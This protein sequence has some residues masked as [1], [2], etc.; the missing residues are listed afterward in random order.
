MLGPIE[1]GAEQGQ[2]EYIKAITASLK[3]AVTTKP[4][5]KGLPR[6]GKRKG[7]Q[8]PVF[9][10]DEAVTQ[11]EAQI[12]HDKMAK[13]WGLLEPVRPLFEPIASI[14]QPFI[15]SQ[16]VIAVLFV[17]LA[18]TWLAPAR[19]PSHGVA[20]PGYS[21]P[22]RIAAYEEIW[23]REESA[24]WDWL[25]DRTGLTD[26]VPLGAG[27][28]HRENQKVLARKL[29]EDERMSERQIDEQIRTTEEKLAGLKEAVERRR[30]KK[31]K[32][33]TA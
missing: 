31:A 18:Y 29:D 10:A 14:L 4:P 19:R 22:E 11:R 9:D 32:N 1:K 16:V 5:V 17:L 2:Q 24:L 13:S 25:E 20:F 7:K 30:A 12:E 21:S 27:V 26:R 8:G 3:A 6:K 15:T 28:R 23:R 33:K